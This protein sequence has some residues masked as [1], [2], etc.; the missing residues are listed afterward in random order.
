MLYNS[1]SFLL[2]T[3]ISLQNIHPG[4]GSGE[5]SEGPGGNVQHG[6]QHRVQE[7]HGQVRHDGGHVEV[8]HGG[9]SQ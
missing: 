1:S 4:A 2:K 6:A 7:R 9:H 8:R 3:L 5:H